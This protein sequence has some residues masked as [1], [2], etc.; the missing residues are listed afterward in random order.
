L[1]DGIRRDLDDGGA[2]IRR[3]GLPAD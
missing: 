2:G 1:R 3:I